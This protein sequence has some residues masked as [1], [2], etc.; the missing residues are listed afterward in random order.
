MIN[1]SE[2]GYVSVKKRKVMRRRNKNTT[3]L[4]C[5]PWTGRRATRECHVVL[6]RKRTLLFV[7]QCRALCVF[8]GM[9][10]R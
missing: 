6:L 9:T 7:R 2:N 4:G 8:L 3:S 10:A 5:L 1:E